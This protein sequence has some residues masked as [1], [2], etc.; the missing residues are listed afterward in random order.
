MSNK[1]YLI[2]TNNKKFDEW[3][4]QNKKRLKDHALEHF[5]AGYN[6]V[7]NGNYL[8]RASFVCYWEIYNSNSLAKI[9]PAITQASFIH[10][11]HRFMERGQQ[12]EV[13]V[14]QQLMGNFLRLLQVLNEPVEMNTDEEE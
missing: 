14:V 11:L 2:T 3:S 7:V 5:N 9:A 10:M 13:I 1:L 8:A 4:K 12:E 6:D